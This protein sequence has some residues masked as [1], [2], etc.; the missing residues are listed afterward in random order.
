MRKMIV[1]VLTALL[2]AAAFFL[3]AELSAWN[4]QQLLD[5]PHITQEDGREGF[6]ESV[7]LTVAEKLLLLQ[8]GTLSSMVLGDLAIQGGMN[9]SAFVT[10]G[11][12]SSEI[13]FYL[14]EASFGDEAA[15]A[16]EAEAADM[17]LEKTRQ[18]WDER[19]TAV[20]SEVRTLQ[21]M[22]AMPQLWDADSELEFYGY[23][24][25]LYVD[26]STR[27]SFQGY[28]MRLD[29]A[30][31][32]L[33]VLVDAQSQ[34]ILAFNLDWYSGTPLNW[35]FRGAANFGTAWRDYW[36]LDSVND[37][38]YSDYVKS[39]L[40]NTDAMLHSNGEYNANGQIIFS[41]GGQSLKIPL[42]N[43]AFYDRNRSLWWNDL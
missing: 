38:W 32:S 15:L 11:E 8:S 18:K 34:R 25:T 35:G 36:G 27:M 10:S 22:G 17:E 29:G 13:S 23:G 24:E 37:S 6:A 41:Y 9:A 42:A 26:S 14:E 33:D 5:E 1:I 2:V 43:W 12:I 30:P 3:P 21:A 19:L 40:E 4:D 28:R 20:R 7:Q 31:F 39:I 16:I